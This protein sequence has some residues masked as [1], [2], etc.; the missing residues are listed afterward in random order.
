VTDHRGL[1]QVVLNLI[2]NG[3]QAINRQGRIQIRTRHEGALVVLE[4][5]DNGPGI[6]E[7]I[8]SRIFDPFYTTKPLGEG[9]GLGLSI[10]AG[11]ISDCGGSIDLESTVGQGA[12]FIV[13]LPV[14]PETGLPSLPKNKKL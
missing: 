6:A 8:R 9:T 4:V 10:C 3:L 13:T 7:D 12:T 2:I 1:E 11:V 5:E 14:K